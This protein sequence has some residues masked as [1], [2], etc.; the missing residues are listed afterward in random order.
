MGPVPPVP[1]L[2]ARSPATAPLM[3]AAT[4]GGSPVVGGTYLIE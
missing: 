3:F 4:L 2:P 1:D